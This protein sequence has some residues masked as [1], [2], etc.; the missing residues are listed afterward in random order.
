MSR[1]YRCSDRLPVKIGDITFKISPLTFQ[2]R[3]EIQSDLMLAS[4]GDMERA[5]QASYKSIKHA[6]KDIS[7]L[8]T[9]DGEDYK[10]SFDNEGSLTDECV[11]DLL[12]LEVFTEL[13]MVAMSLLKG[14]P[15]KILD[16][17]GKEIKGITLLYKE[18]SNLPNVQKTKK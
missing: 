10:L 16:N 18:G 12:N 2:A 5:V 6:V 14:V 15:D 11:S 17:D 9:Y 7:G 3:S 4:K 13:A 8:E 1:I